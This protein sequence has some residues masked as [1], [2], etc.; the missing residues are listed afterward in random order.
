MPCSNCNENS[1]FQVYNN[2]STYGNSCLPVECGGTLT[3]AKCVYYSGPA[4]PCSGIG[5]N[6]SLEVALQKIDEKICT[7]VGDYSTYNT[8]CLSPITTQKQFVESISSYVCTNKALFDTFVGTTFTAYQAAVNS[9]FIDL[10]SPGIT[11]TIAGVTNTDS[12]YNVLNKYCSTFGDIYDNLNISG[13]NFGQCFSVVTPPTSIAGAFSLL[14]DQI[15][16]VQASAGGALPIFN[17]LG[18]CLPTPGS[19]DTLASTIDK[20]KTR[21]CQTGTFDAGALSFGCATPETTLQ[22][23]VQ[24]ILTRVDDYIKNKLTFSSDFSITQ[25]DSGN[26]CLGKTVALTT[27]IVGNDRL[28]ATSASDTT[29]GYLLDKVVGTSL[30]TVTE[31]GTNPTKQIQIATSAIASV[32]HNDTISIALLGA[33]TSVSPLTANLKISATAGNQAILNTDGLYVA[34]IATIYTFNSTNSITLTNVSNSITAAVRIDTTVPNL[35]QANANGLF[36]TPQTVTET[37]ISVVSTD[38]LSLAVS[39]LNNHT[40]TGNVAISATLGNAISVNPDGLYV[41]NSGITLTT[42]GTSGAATLVGTVLN[43]PNYAGGISLTALSA[44]DPLFYNNTT[45]VFTI[46]QAGVATQGYLSSTDWNTFNDKEHAL[47]F[48]TGLSRIGNTITNTITQYTDSLARAAISLTTTGTSGAATYNSTTGVLNVP[49][50]ATSLTGYVPYTGATGDVNLGTHNILAFGGTFSSS[51]SA[52]ATNVSNAY[53]YRGFDYTGTYTIAALGQTNS[54]EGYLL[55]SDNTGNVSTF[56]QGN[57]YTKINDSTYNSYSVGIG[58][59]ADN[60]ST[61]KLQVNGA[62]SAVLASSTQSNIVYYNSSTGLFTYSTAPVTINAYS[63]LTQTGG[64]IVLGG[65]L[66]ADAQVDGGT[67]YTFSSK[68]TLLS[69]NH[70]A[71]GFRGYGYLG[72]NGTETQQYAVTGIYGH[73]QVENASGTFT[74]YS[75]SKHGA[76]SGTVYKKNTGIFAGI[77]PAVLG[78]LEFEGSGNVTTAVALRALAPELT[79]SSTYTGTITNAVGLYIDDIGASTVLAQ[80]T[81]RYAIW[82]VGTGDTNLFNGIINIPNLPTY[83]DNTAAAGLPTGQLYKTATGVVMVKY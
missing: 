20:I 50:Y 66:A 10:E 26:A 77:L 76:I 53:I 40:I 43:V 83:A 42:T 64:N 46:T 67:G 48:S 71:F 61:A 79:Q 56:I 24:Q 17:N 1:P 58:Y 72:V 74:P 22:D 57:G 49:N 27:P 68:A 7:V 34:T 75:L 2:Q 38:S 5:I 15:C 37:P 9:R 18:S 16:Q 63:G 44:V 8:Y 39:G 30:I 21:L 78:V 65:A 3:N 62:I 13:V 33:G 82:Q 60:G 11:C 55:V 14:V 23:T 47:V 29:P 4:L 28:V 51:I 35:L 54:N 19:A 32:S 52:V 45:G 12:I 81:N 25:T 80:I 41:A 70:N 6:D 36:V 69:A 31:I 59:G 73:L